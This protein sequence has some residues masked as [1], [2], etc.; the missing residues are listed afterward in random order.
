MKILK[1]L[2]IAITSLSVLVASAANCYIN[3]KK[4]CASFSYDTTWPEGDVHVSCNKSSDLGKKWQY[5]E[6]RRDMDSG[7]FCT[8]YP[9][10]QRCDFTCI[11]V[12]QIDGS[13][14]TTFETY[15]FQTNNCATNTCIDCSP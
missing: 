8:L 9:L 12:L 11:A 10:V 4:S 6:A 13:Y 5:S 14:L 15:R 3:I 1:Y 7:R 2:L